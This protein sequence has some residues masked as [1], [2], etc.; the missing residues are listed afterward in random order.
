MPFLWIPFLAL[1]LLEIIVF[2]AVADAIGFFSALAA[3][4]LAAL[5]GA[6]LIK[7]QGLS[8]FMKAQDQLR[9]G[10]MPLTALFHGLCV[11]IAG[12]LFIVPGFVTDFLGLL[13]LIPTIQSRV[14]A[15][16]S[17]RMEPAPRDPDIIDGEFERV[18]DAPPERLR[19]P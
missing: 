6:F 13:L 11:V 15:F 9:D 2:L 16:L 17:P 10:Q 7:Q 18:D 5:F 8:Q 12:F 19:R 3:C 1:P 4:I 14:R